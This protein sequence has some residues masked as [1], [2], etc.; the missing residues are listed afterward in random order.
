MKLYNIYFYFSVSRE[1]SIMYEIIF[2]F[3]QY[4]CWIATIATISYCIYIHSLD[5]DLC[6]IDYKTYY[7]D[8]NDVFPQLS[9]C[10]KDPISEEKLKSYNFT[11]NISSYIN[12]LDGN[13]FDSEMLKIDYEDVIKNLSSY[14]E[15][16]WI[17]YSNGTFLNLHPDN[18]DAFPDAMN[19]NKVDRPSVAIFPSVN[20]FFSYYLDNTF[21]NCYT[22]PIP[23]DKNIRAYYFKVNNTI[24]K[25]GIRTNQY[26]LVTIIHYPN[27]MLT[28][29]STMKYFWPYVRY[30]NDS[31]IM[32]YKLYG[33][34]K[35]RRRQKSR[36]PCSENWKYYDHEIKETHVKKHGCRPPYLN[37]P[38]EDPICS[39][40]NEI[41]KAKF[42]YRADHYHTLPACTTMENIFYEYDESPL[43]YLPSDLVIGSFRIMIM[44]DHHVFKEISQTR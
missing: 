12:F 42:L 31:Y 10:L 9:F 34:E 44:L 5:E 1:K 36:Q 24:F 8:E 22:L 39:D 19:V 21:L 7:K 37:Y 43:T 40:Q 4:V 30:E 15:P 35:L 2:T 20:A 18:N 41:K 38:K 3:Y 27:H 11:F 14:I 28:S 26:D 33:V 17:D 13:S 29:I 25:D 6:T 32:K 23:Q 16:T